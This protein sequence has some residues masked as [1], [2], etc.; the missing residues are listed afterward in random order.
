MCGI[1]SDVLGVFPAALALV[2]ACL[3]DINGHA[4]KAALKGTFALTFKLDGRNDKHVCQLIKVG[5]EEV[6][7]LALSEKGNLGFE[8]GADD[9]CVSGLFKGFLNIVA[10]SVNFV[11]RFDKSVLTARPLTLGI[12]L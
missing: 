5:F 4:L 1:C 6:E 12:S 8:R 2:S 9:L 10:Q 7:G 11:P 3:L